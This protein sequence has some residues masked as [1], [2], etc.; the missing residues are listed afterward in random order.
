MKLFAGLTDYL[1]RTIP[2]LVSRQPIVW[3]DDFTIATA[4]S[5]RQSLA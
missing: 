2:H 3:V 1:F 5:T 4:C